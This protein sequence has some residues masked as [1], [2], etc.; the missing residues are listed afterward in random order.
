MRPFSLECHLSYRNA[1]IAIKIEINFRE[2]IIFLDKLEIQ[3]VDGERKP[4]VRR[5]HNSFAKYGGQHFR[6]TKAGTP[7]RSPVTKK[8]SIS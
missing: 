6:L 1:E 8:E 3:N 7:T 2:L 4:L 5:N